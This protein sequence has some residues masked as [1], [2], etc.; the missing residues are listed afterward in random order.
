MNP[1][2][3][4]KTLQALRAAHQ[5]LLREKE[6]RDQ[7]DPEAHDETDEVCGPPDHDEDEVDP[8]LDPLVYPPRR[9]P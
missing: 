5:T 1:E 8:S 9:S 6:D 2:D 4:Q 7:G 3:V